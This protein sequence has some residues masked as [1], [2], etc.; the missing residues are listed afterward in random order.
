MV[1]RFIKKRIRYSAWTGKKQTIIQILSSRCRRDG[2]PEYGRFTSKEIKQIISQVD[3][4]IKELMLYFNDLDNIGNYQNEYVGLIDLAIYRSLVK[5]NV[6]RDYAVKLVGDMMW[7]A[8]LNAKGLIPIID[9][10]KKKLTKLTTKNPLDYLGKRIET[11]MKYPYSPPGY[12]IKLYKENDVYCMDIYSCPVYDFYK[13]FGQEEMVLFR[14]STCTFDYSAAEYAVEGG[15]YQ[16]IHTHY[17][18][19]MR[20]MICGGILKVNKIIKKWQRLDLLLI[21]A[22]SYQKMW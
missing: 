6:S 2:M 15:K 1:N 19:A 4:N 12:K 13:Q 11:M 5:K 16:R 10:I 3:L 7:Q 9:P 18:M 14:R 22:L 20:C 8:V 17:L 21:I